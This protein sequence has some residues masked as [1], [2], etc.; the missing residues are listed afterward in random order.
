MILCVIPARAGSKRIPG[1]NVRAFCGKPI[2]AWSISAAIGAGIF[3]HVIVSTDSSEIAEVARNHGAEVPFLR[4]AALADDFTGTNAVTRHA[5]QVMQ[6]RAD[7]VITE[8]C[9]LYATAPF[10]VGSDLKSGLQHLRASAAE[11]CFAATTFDFPVQR[12]LVIGQNGLVVPMFPE[13]IS[14]RSQDLAEALH[15]AGQF[16]WGTPASFSAHDVGFNGRSAPLFMPRW[17]V[18]DIDTEEDWNRAEQL[19]RIQRTSIGA[20]THFSY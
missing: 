8:V 7:E 2:I 10:V 18:Q 14:H 17:R 12:A 6:G 13:W 16:Y 11:F 3:D 19:F 20:E 5:I 9:C 4:P 1:K 15:D